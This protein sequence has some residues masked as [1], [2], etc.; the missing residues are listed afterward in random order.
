MVYNTMIVFRI[1]KSRRGMAVISNFGL[2]PRAKRQYAD[3]DPPT[4]NMYWYTRRKQPEDSCG[5][6]IC[7][8][9]RISYRFGVC[10]ANKYYLVGRQRKLRLSE[11]QQRTPRVLGSSTLRR[12]ITSTTCSRTSMDDHEPTAPTGRPNYR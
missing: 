7:I 11:A 10:A 6:Q 1:W 2:S 12:V 4:P 3:P 5:S 9:L 8:N